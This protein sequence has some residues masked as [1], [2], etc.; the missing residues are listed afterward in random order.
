M[1]KFEY[2]Q[3]NWLPYGRK[4]VSLDINVKDNYEQTIDFVKLRKGKDIDNQRML[5]R[6]KKYGFNLDTPIDKEE[7][8]EK[9]KQ[10]DI[11]WLN[12]K[13]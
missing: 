7:E 5:K 4:A 10:E 2:K 6:I 8:I 11:D 13:K 1:S 12:D 9:E 3:S